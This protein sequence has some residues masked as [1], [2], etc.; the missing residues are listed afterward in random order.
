MSHFWK[1]RNTILFLVSAALLVL[2]SAQDDVCAIQGC[3]YEGN[4]CTCSPDC[5][6]DDDI[7]CCPGAGSCKGEFR[8]IIAENEVTRSQAANHCQKMG[9]EL[10]SIIDQ[11]MTDEINRLVVLAEEDHHNDGAG[12]RL[13][14]HQGDYWITAKDAG[15]EGNWGSYTPWAA[16]QPDGGSNENCAVVRIELHSGTDVEMGWHDESCTTLH[17]FIC[18][19]NL[20]S[21]D[22]STDPKK[23]PAPS[24]PG[25]NDY[26]VFT[27][28]G[29]CAATDCSL[30]SSPDDGECFCD[31]ECYLYGDCCEDVCDGCQHAYCMPESCAAYGCGS[32]GAQQACQC[33]ELC[34]EHGDC[35]PDVCSGIACGD[36]YEL[37]GP[38][39]SKMGVKPYGGDYGGGMCGMFMPNAECQCYE[40]CERLGNCCADICDTCADIDFCKPYD[41]D[42]KDDDKDW[43][44]D[45]KDD[46]DTMTKM[47][48][49]GPGMDWECPPG[50]T[51]F[52]SKASRRNLRRLQFGM[53]EEGDC[54]C[55][56]AM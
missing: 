4:D 14:G 21:E 22:D 15:D 48:C 5:E 36:T 42:D 35:C 38:T 6:I 30:H 39:C 24:P 16:G 44:D 55:V 8:F 53:F 2:A 28:S 33:D 54:V 29:A 49:S 50:Y 47:L 13:A 31:S 41:D 23:T 9:G 17:K 25:G 45:D 12:R 1:S 32:V 40:G 56:K 3:D 11:A 43:G 7:D 10:V 19:G 20:L 51:C 37:C 34:F 18:Q 46:S 27:P 52:C 26:P